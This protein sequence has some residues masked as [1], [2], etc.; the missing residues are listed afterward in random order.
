[1]E[2]LHNI[3]LFGKEAINNAVKYSGASKLE[4]GMHFLDNTVELIIKDDGKGF[5]VSTISNGN[6]LF[7]MQKRADEEGATFSLQSSPKEGTVISL[8][9][10]ITQ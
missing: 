1:V 5:D 10:R 9:C 6:G 8:K 7:N 2:S 4:V 3:Y